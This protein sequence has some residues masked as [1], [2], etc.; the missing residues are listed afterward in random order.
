VL[1]DMSIL[2]L[3]G[4]EMK[5]M[6]GIAGKMFSTLGEHEIN[7]EMISQGRFTPSYCSSL[8]VC[9][10]MVWTDANHVLLWVFRCQRNQHLVRH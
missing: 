10:W 3:V 2:S 7:I 1:H 8:C 9:V 5:N 4:A 6:P